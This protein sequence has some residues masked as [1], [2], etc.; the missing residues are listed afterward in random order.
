MTK[1]LKTTA[2]AGVAALA[3]AGSASALTFGSIPDGAFNNGLDDVYGAGTTE[4][5]GYYGAQLYFSGPA[6]TELT[7]EY[8]GAEGAFENEFHYKDSLLFTTAGVD[9]EGTWCSTSLTGCTAPLASTT[10]TV[11]AGLID[12]FFKSPLGDA[13]NGFNADNAL[14]ATEVNYFVTFDNGEASTSGQSVVL[15]FDDDGAN[16]DDNHD[17]MAIRLTLKGGNVVADVPLPAA[18]WM[19][20]AGLGG[21]GAVARRKK[22]A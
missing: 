14:G 12:F 17:D 18:G 7:I 13:V 22:K 11:S 1:F 20:L 10:V 21:L 9:G 8:L 6:D 2:L 19:L 3:M 16:D 15:W 5:S 4:R